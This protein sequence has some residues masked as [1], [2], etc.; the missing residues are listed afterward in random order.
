MA[1]RR[2]G[3]WI[4][5]ARGG[6][7]CTTI[8]GLHALQ[9]GLTPAT[10]LVTALPAFAP[11]ELLGWDEL[12][13]G[14]HEIRPT[15]LRDELWRL[16]HDDRLFSAELLEAI[17]PDL[18][19]TESRI[20]PGLVRRPGDAIERLAPDAAETTSPRAVVEHLQ[21]D[22]SR[23]IESND[24]DS[25]VVVNLASTEPVTTEALWHDDLDA[26]QAE[27][28]QDSSTVPVSTLQAFGTLEL[29]LPFVNFTPSLGA[30]IPA[31]DQLAAEK[32]ACHAGRDGKTGETLLKSA[33]AAV[34]ADRNLEVMSWVG[35]NIFGNRDGQVL[36]NP[37]NK[38]AKVVSK[39]Q[40]LA[41]VLGYAPQ[42]LVSIEHIE[43]LGDWKTAWDHIH[44]QGFLGTPMTLQFTWQGC[45]SALAAPLVL[46]LVRLCAC[47]A[48]RG[49]RG[50]LRH[51]SCFFKSP[52]GSATHRFDHQVAVLKQ[53]LS[54]VDKEEHAE[55][56]PAFSGE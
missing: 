55:S 3:I 2:T 28:D 18:A 42:T 1:E 16:H 15:T 40:A 11:L 36:D 29:G 51:L 31:L 35:H 13:V 46:D 12:I 53:W 17:E 19:Q 27:L 44:F 45:D 20:R 26:L 56:Q 39:D 30:S 24:L 49:E 43:S 41:S 8:A 10:G 48:S 33:L 23:F 21:R 34:F 52:V 38:A 9:R 54:D 25:A 47:S 4:I 50:P 37:A 22:L 5:G 6:V 32:G 7:A 14:G